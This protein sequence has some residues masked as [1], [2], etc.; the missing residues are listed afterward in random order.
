MFGSSDVSE[1]LLDEDDAGGVDDV[2]GPS[3][4]TGLWS[5]LRQQRVEEEKQPHADPSSTSS[6]QP[7]PSHSTTSSSSPY[8]SSPL[9]PTYVPS[10]ATVVPAPRLPSS[11]AVPSSVRRGSA[12]P[13]T[14]G[15]VSGISRGDALMAADPLD[16]VEPRSTY[17]PFSSPRL[18]RLVN[19]ALLFLLSS[20]SQLSY[21]IQHSRVEMRKRKFNYCLGSLSCFV[22][23]TV[24]AVCYTLIAR[25]PVVFLQ[26]AESQQG[27][28][29][30]RLDIDS[31]S[32]ANFLN[33]SKVAHNLAVGEGLGY[34]SP[35]Q[36]WGATIYGADCVKTAAG[37]GFNVSQSDWMYTGLGRVVPCTNTSTDC[38]RTICPPTSGRRQQDSVTLILA[39][40]ERERR[41]GLGRLWEHLAIPV[42]EA[43]ITE[44]TATARGLQVGDVFL[45]TSSSYYNLLLNLVTEGMRALHG[46][47]YFHRNTTQYMT[48]LLREFASTVQLSVRVRAIT[49]NSWAGKLGDG[50][51]DV[52]MMEFEPFL[53][54]LLQQ[55]HP[56][57]RTTPFTQQVTANTQPPA[58]LQEPS[59]LTATVLPFSLPYYAASS[60]STLYE[61]AN[62]VLLNLRPNRI[63]TYM[64]TNYDDIQDTV[65]NWAS[66][67][68]YY[69]SFPQLSISMPILTSLYGFRF[70]SL[71]LGLILS[72][73]LTIL[74]ILSTML[75]YSLLMISIETR[76]FEL[77]VHRMV[78]MTTSGIIN[79]LLVQACSYSIPAWVIGLVISQIAAAYLCGVLEDRVEVPVSRL[80]TAYS[81]LVASFLGLIIPLLAAILPIRTALSKNLHD[82]L[83]TQHS[84]TMGVQ[85]NIE[86]SEDKGLNSA[87]L[88]VGTGFVVFGFLI[89]YLLPLSLLSFNLTLFFNLFFGLLLGLLFGLI[90]LALNFQHMLE[91]VHAPHATMLHV[92]PFAPPPTVATAQHPHSSSLTLHL[93]SSPQLLLRLFFFWEKPQIP[94]L[95]SKNL[96]AHRMRN[97]KT[98]IMFA[99]SLGFIIFIT[100]A[101]A[102]E[103]ASAKFRE[104]QQNG[105]SVAVTS[106]NGYWDYGAVT[107]WETF[108]QQSPL[109]DDWAWVTNRMGAQGGEYDSTY[110]TN[111]GHA[112]SAV[113]QIYGVSANFYECTLP[114][115]LIPS[116]QDE[117]TSLSLS[118]Q[119]YTVRG[120]QSAVIGTNAINFY[121]LSG[122]D[123]SSSFLLSMQRRDPASLT[124]AR[125]Q[126]MSFL[127]LSPRL[128]FTQFP[129]VTTQTAIVS[130]PTYVELSNGTYSSLR[131][132][133]YQYLIV[134]QASGNKDADVD[135][136]V[137]GLKDVGQSGASV[138]DSRSLG[139]SLA[140]ADSV[141]ALIFDSAT[142][143]AMGLCLFS[144]MASMFTNIYEQSK[145][146]AILRA[147][148]LPAFAIIRV[149][150]YEAFVLV[151]GASILGM[152]I[153]ALMS[154]TMSAQ[155]VLFTQLPVSVPF[156]WQLVVLVIVGS[157]VCAIV[158]SCLPARRLMAKKISTIFRTVL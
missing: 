21:F 152:C 63:D 111:L 103:I 81:I 74:F 26:Q 143:V 140:K 104:L 114:D 54:W 117:S 17:H 105:Q 28:F 91:K 109:V 122:L 144:L 82:S 38:M 157:F 85:F 30:A 25:A 94:L 62:H 61:H 149:Y 72:I 12:T 14:A 8:F 132:L 51:D 15:P 139:E 150:T 115:F 78:G 154:T 124:L 77:G 113:V 147:M 23:V 50:S 2:S 116:Q 110:M 99:L 19:S 93:L 158:A 39:D 55:L 37:K 24:A 1:K 59:T 135:A 83:D 107:A 58:V 44:A 101:Y 42:G 56:V 80:L 60:P 13:S 151:L 86:R 70:F 138:Y 92:D 47:D 142:Y 46:D 119:L 71:F 133:H 29:D 3:T 65:V 98:S 118:E 40:T 7:P 146:I 18:N 141:M 32:R 4:S 69:A 148:G 131:D 43:I 84:K 35:R 96:I 89:Y 76:T 112:F 106:R 137:Q 27:Q 108:L 88:A 45:L 129:T 120:A 41:M 95:V 128:T 97:R 20:S 136:L 68:M 126:P 57:L 6:Y 33:Y 134:K 87:W 11:S 79:M 121:H 22:V 145:E 16:A 156:P 64:S 125:L 155:R 73:I 67:V 9:P 48:Q 90:L 31:A 100:V 5:R 130:L 49:S 66:S 153:G 75:I 52:L 102:M 123:V 10:Q 127:D 53:P 36:T 34:H